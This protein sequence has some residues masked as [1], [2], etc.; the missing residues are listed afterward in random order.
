MLLLL[1]YFHVLPAPS[2]LPC[3]FVYFGGFL[4]ASSSVET[5]Q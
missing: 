4:Y 1:A 5:V 2:V 3:S